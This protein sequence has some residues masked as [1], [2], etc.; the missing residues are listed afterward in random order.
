MI[1]EKITKTEFLN[2]V[3]KSFDVGDKLVHDDEQINWT[4]YGCPVADYNT[5]TGQA[6]FW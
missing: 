1:T 2:R 4:N 5:V 6:I 3:M